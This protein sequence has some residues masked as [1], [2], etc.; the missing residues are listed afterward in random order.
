M[1]SPP[2]P[3]TPP[4]KPGRPSGRQKILIVDDDAEVMLMMVRFL[5]RSGYEILQCDGPFGATGLVRRHAPDAVILDIMMPALA[6]SDLVHLLREADPD[7]PVL[8]FSAIDEEQ[9][10]ALSERVRGS[11]FL[12]KTA[13]VVA[14]ERTVSAMLRGS[15]SER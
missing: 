13:G 2:T 11:A 5:G 15:G 14:L 1:Q 10:R 12:S 8:F 7:L 4:N 6:G 3:P 9:G